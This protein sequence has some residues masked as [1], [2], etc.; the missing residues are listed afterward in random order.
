LSAPR[1]PIVVILASAGRPALLA[2][3]I[4]DLSR[5]T[6]DF[7][8]IVSVP[9][10]A[11]L[12]PA[13]SLSGAVVVRGRR[14]SAAQRNAGLDAAPDAELVF[15]FDDDAVIRS[16][17]LERGVDFF[18]AHPE[19]NGITGRVLLDGAG[20][21]EIPRAAAEKAIAES[22]AA[23]VRHQFR[24][25]KELYGCNFAFRPSGAGGERFDSRLPLYSW[26]EDYD[27]ARR[28]MRHG[29]LAKVDDCV[30]VHRGAKS[31]GRFAHER[32]GYSQMMNPTYFYHGG[33]FSLLV[34]LRETVFR[35]GKNVVRSVR[36]AERHWRRERLHGNL[37][38]LG[39]IARGRLTPERIL[40]L[41][42]PRTGSVDTLRRISELCYTPVGSR[43][44]ASTR[45]IRSAS[46]GARNAA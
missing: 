30:I 19:V 15:F 5:Q 42:A 9:D 20:R 31:G 14:S 29:A 8:L 1:S 33:S 28:L 6:I 22:L 4:S 21:E 32:L 35:L 10:D 11:S 7:T 46:S 40:E 16:D 23:P 24:P 36:G 37:I 38:A 27:F 34:A 26:L 43:L 18:R 13:G 12:P 25:S 3:V 44:S 17:Y 45:L 41:P 39:D 2:D